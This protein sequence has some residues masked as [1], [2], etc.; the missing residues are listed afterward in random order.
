[1]A[2]RRVFSNDFEMFVD[3]TAGADVPVGATLINRDSYNGKEFYRVP[4]N[5]ERERLARLSS[6]AGVQTTPIAAARAWQLY[7]RIRR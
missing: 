1:M 3:L 5:F 7:F 4:E 6:R 2:G